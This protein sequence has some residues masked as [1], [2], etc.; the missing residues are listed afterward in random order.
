MQSLIGYCPQFDALIGSMSGQEHLEYYARVR[1][2]SD[3]DERNV[4]IYSIL[5]QHIMLNT[6]NRILTSLLVVR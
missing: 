2:L 1:G 5:V 6:G 4:R 3:E